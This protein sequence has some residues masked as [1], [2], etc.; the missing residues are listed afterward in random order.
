MI[1]AHLAAER[2]ILSHTLQEKIMPLHRKERLPLI[3][4]AASWI[5]GLSHPSAEPLLS[6]WPRSSNKKQICPLTQVPLLPSS[7]LPVSHPGSLRKPA[8]PPLSGSS[9]PGWPL[10]VVVSSLGCGYLSSWS[11]LST[12]QTQCFFIPVFHVLAHVVSK[13]L[14]TRL[15]VAR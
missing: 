1:Q 13:C 8:L 9:L 3:P 7:L 10:G 5:Q 11:Y 12:G 6:H 14:V 15:A 2:S 4:A